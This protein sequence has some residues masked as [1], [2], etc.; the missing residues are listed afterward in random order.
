VEI[1]LNISTILSLFYSG[2]KVLFRM[3]IHWISNVNLQTTRAIC[4]LLAGRKLNK[5]IFFDFN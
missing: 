3:T 2:E 4:R 5:S 1:L